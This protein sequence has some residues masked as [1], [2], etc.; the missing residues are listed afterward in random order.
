MLPCSLSLAHHLKKT[1]PFDSPE[2]PKKKKEDRQID[3]Q[4]EYAN[5]LNH[6]RSIKGP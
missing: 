5:L 4:R 6:G 2:P 3:T 1:S